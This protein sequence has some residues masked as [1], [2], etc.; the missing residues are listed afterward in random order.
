MKHRLYC[1]I[2]MGPWAVRV[3]TLQTGMPTMSLCCDETLSPFALLGEIPYM[4]TKSIVLGK[5]AGI[6]QNIG[7][8]R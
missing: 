6:I 8:C 4:P 1:I 5:I 2:V 7:M 3:Q